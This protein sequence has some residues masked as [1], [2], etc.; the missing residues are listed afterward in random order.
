M[1]ED[2]ILHARLME[3]HEWVAVSKM[4]S[5]SKLV[6]NKD[7]KVVVDLVV[8]VQLLLLNIRI[9]KPRVGQ[10]GAGN[11]GS[12]LRHGITCPNMYILILE[13]R[14]SLDHVRDKLSTIIHL[15]HFV[16]ISKSKAFRSVSLVFVLRL[17]QFHNC[18][19][20]NDN[21]WGWKVDLQVIIRLM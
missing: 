11:N 13:I 18:W 17:Y 9:S 3:V 15:L 4:K 10:V 2:I 12:R 21:A 7:K 20:P 8:S 14:I 19:S 1:I 5:R 6:P 16:K